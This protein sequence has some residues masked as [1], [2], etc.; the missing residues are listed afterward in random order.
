ME[1]KSPRLGVTVV[2]VTR[3]LRRELALISLFNNVLLSL[4]TAARVTKDGPD[5]FIISKD[6]GEPLKLTN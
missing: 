3:D 2:D 1:F 6:I 4:S 5:G